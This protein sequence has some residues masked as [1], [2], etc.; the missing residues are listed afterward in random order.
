M[1]AALIAAF[2]AAVGAADPVHTDAEAARA[3]GYGDVIAPPTM[4]VRFSQAVGAGLHRRPRGRHRLQPGRPR[5]AAVRP[6]P[7]DHGRRRGPRHDDRRRGALRRR[8]RDGDDPHRAVH[9]RRRGAGDVDVDDRRPR[10]GG[11]S[12]AA[13]PLS[14]VSVGDV[15]GPV[16]RARRARHARRLRQRLRRPEPHPPGRGVRPLGGAAR[17]HRPRHVDDGRV[18]HRRRRLG[19]ATPAGSW[20]SAPGSPSRSSCPVTGN[21][22]VVEGVVKAVDAETRTRHGRRHDDVR[23]REG[24]RPLRRRRAARL[25]QEAVRRADR[26]AHDDAGRRAGRAAGR[27]RDRRRAGRRRARGRRRRRAAAGVGGG[28]NLVVADAGFA[29]TVVKVA[30]RGVARR[31]RRTSAAAPT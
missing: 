24:P 10:R 8:P 23:R 19:R 16:H 15:V 9:D 27:R 22:I 3:A 20:S 28:S 5:R 18:R 7:A 14:E 30:T 26:P 6:P 2:A 31:L 25:M 12:M 17:R 13:R 29:G 1:D 21:E 11:V 4:A